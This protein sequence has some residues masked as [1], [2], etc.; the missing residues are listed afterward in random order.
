MPQMTLFGTAASASKPAEPK[1]LKQPASP[2]GT[3]LFRVALCVTGAAR[4]FIDVPEVA[5][6]LRHAIADWPVDV[7]FH[8][9]LGEELSARGQTGGSLAQAQQ[10]NS[11]MARLGA[12]VHVV[13]VQIQLDENEF[14]CGQ[15]TNGRFYKMGRCAR[16]VAEYS[17]RTGTNYSVFVLSRPD[18][19]FESRLDPATCLAQFAATTP[20]APLVWNPPAKRHTEG[21]VTIASFS[22]LSTFTDLAQRDKVECCDEAKR[23]PAACFYTSHG[24]ALKG[25]PPPRSFAPTSTFPAADCAA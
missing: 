25:A 23:T 4:S 17:K 13:D 21:E 3:P 12:R 2:A 14:E 5:D 16:S 22:G 11:S 18:L 15:M 7:F 10:L 6:S 24:I 8:V 19:I 20:S 9:L 1:L